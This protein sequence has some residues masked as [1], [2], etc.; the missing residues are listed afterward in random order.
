[1][2]FNHIDIHNF[3]GIESLTIKNIKQVNL[4]TG[5]NNCGK[6]SVLEAIFLL[7]GMSNPQLILSIHS[8]RNISLTDNDD[9]SYIFNNFDLSQYP[10]ITGQLDSHKRNLKIKAVDSITLKPL[11]HNSEQLQLPKEKPKT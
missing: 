5:R 10:S 11:N 2:F 6:T 9:F 7:T 8:F 1:M 4:I 3:R